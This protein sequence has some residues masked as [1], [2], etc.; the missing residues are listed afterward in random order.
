VSIAR[1]NKFLPKPEYNDEHEK[2]RNKDHVKAK[3]SNAKV[4][5]VA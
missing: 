2:K 1:K 3:K 5:E 4:K